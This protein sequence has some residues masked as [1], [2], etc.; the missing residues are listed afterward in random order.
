MGGGT[1]VRA[2]ACRLAN[3]YAKPSVILTHYL[4]S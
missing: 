2:L 1:G 4:S 3:G